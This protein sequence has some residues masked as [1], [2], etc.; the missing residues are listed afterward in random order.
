[1]LEERSIKRRR[2]TVEKRAN[3]STDIQ[4]MA[5]ELKFNY[6]INIF[7]FNYYLNHDNKN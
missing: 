7:K 3:Q 2:M 1:M 5:L 6:F 4:P